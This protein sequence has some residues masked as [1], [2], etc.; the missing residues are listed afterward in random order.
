MELDLNSEQSASVV[1]LLAGAVVGAVLVGQV[2]RRC[3]P[4]PDAGSLYLDLRV[5][6]KKPANAMRKA[7][8]RAMARERK[9]RADKAAKASRP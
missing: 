3:F 2:L 1:P 7:F 6:S 5:V 9:R 4:H 8:R